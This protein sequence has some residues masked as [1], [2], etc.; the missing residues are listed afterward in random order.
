MPGFR[1]NVPYGLRD[2]GLRLRRR[3]STSRSNPHKGLLDG[4]NP[5]QG[6]GLLALA[7]Q[8]ARPCRS[9][10]SSTCMEQEDHPIVRFDG[11]MRR[12]F[13]MGRRRLPTEAEWEY[14]AR[15][16]R[17]EW[18]YPWGNFPQS[19]GRQLPRNRLARRLDLHLAGWQFPQERLRPL[20]CGGEC[21]GVLA[22]WYAPNYYSFSPEADPAGPAGGLE[23]VLVGGSF[24][25][26]SGCCASRTG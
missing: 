17:Q 26:R 6:R 9:R 20:R 19:R 12:R 16:G 18:K 15:G 21:M 14:S 5:S 23:R 24:F 4:T 7:R 3:A 11:R 2:R 22:D 8:P 25:I 1:R 13:A 10:P